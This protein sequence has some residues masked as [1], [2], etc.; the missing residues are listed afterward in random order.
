MVSIIDR[1]YILYLTISLSLSLSLSIDPVQRFAFAT[2]SSEEERDKIVNNHPTLTLSNGE[3]ITLSSYQNRTK[4]VKVFIGNLAY[5][6]NDE[7]I[8]E[9]LEDVVGVNSFHSVKVG[10]DLDGRQKGFAFASFY[11]LEAANKAIENLNGVEVFGRNIVVQ[12]AR[13]KDTVAPGS[14][15]KVEGNHNNERLNLA[16][17]ISSE[18]VDNATIANDETP[19]EA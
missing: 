19:S 8:C 13:A 15:K 17:S 16:E 14:D 4:S 2:V 9:M 5:E 1:S 11:S 18:P 3:N 7:L 10:Y 6:A 12:I